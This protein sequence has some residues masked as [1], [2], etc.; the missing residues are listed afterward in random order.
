MH[1]L[2]TGHSANASGHKKLSHQRS[3][4]DATA[5]IVTSNAFQGVRISELLSKFTCN[6][7]VDK[8]NRIPFNELGQALPRQDGRQ[9]GREGGKGNSVN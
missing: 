1:R 8:L 4:S 9:E 6:K 7:Q 5:A 3:R 2:S